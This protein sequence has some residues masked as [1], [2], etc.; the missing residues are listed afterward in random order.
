MGNHGHRAEG[1]Q[2]TRSYVCAA[3]TLWKESLGYLYEVDLEVA[4]VFKG[5]VWVKGAV[6]S[7][8]V[9]CKPHSVADVGGKVMMRHRHTQTQRI[10]A[11]QHHLRCRETQASQQFR[12]MTYFRKY[13]NNV[14]LNRIARVTKVRNKL[15]KKDESVSTDTKYQWSHERFSWRFD[16]PDSYSRLW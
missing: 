15:Y 13:E 3:W 11:T 8:E 12:N 14:W 6:N 5:G 9:T 10:C 4:T 2:V 16:H 7:K 1:S